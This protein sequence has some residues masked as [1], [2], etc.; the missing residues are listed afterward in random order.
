MIFKTKEAFEEKVNR[1][2]NE[3]ERELR[4][5]RRM[6]ELEEQVRK[7]AWRVNAL[8]AKANPQVPVAEE[9]PTTCAR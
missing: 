3:I 7:L 8:E 5:D 4:N 9:Y 6:F 2:V 1:R